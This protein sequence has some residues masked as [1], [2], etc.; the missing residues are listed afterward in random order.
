MKLGRIQMA[1][2]QGGT[3][4]VSPEEAAE[5]VFTPEEERFLQHSGMRATVGSQAE[6]VA[7]LDGIAEQYGTDLIGVVTICYD[8]KARL[9]SYELL[10]E[11]Y[12]S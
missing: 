7:E 10:A 3:G 5:H 6:V 12:L 1:R 2:N 9:R 11:A 4:I 8:F